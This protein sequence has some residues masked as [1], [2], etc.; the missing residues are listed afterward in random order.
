MGHKC[1]ATVRQP[2]LG[3]WKNDHKYL[4]THQDCCG[5]TAKISLYKKACFRFC[6]PYGNQTNVTQC[7]GEPRRSAGDRVP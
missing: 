3:L 2:P 1:P 7:H 4:L 5:E 6:S